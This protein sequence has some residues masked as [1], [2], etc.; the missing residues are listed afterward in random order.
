M[1]VMNIFKKLL[2]TEP[3]EIKPILKGILIDECLIHFENSKIYANQQKSVGEILLSEI[4]EIRTDSQDVDVAYTEHLILIKLFGDSDVKDFL[5]YD[6]E[7]IK[8]AKKLFAA[9]HIDFDIKHFSTRKEMNEVIYK[10]V[11]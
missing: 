1:I 11:K 3:E 6:R 9:L 4:K 7:D 10:R 8:F 5:I 2:R